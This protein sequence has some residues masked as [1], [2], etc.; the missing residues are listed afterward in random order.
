MFVWDGTADLDLFDQWTYEVDTWAELNELPDRVVIKLMI[1]FMKGEAGKFFMRHVSTRQS[2]WTVKKL[3]EALFDYCFPSDY[4]ARLRAHLER[5]YQGKN[6]VRDFVR[7]IQQLAVR[8]P[9]VTDFQLVQIFWKGLNTHLR[10][11]L[12]E[13]GLNPEKTKLDKLVKY[14]VRKEDAYTEAR[15]EERSFTGKVPGRKWGRFDSRV[16][17]PEAYQPDK[18]Q[19]EGAFAKNRPRTDRSGQSDTKRTHT[20]A[21]KRPRREGGHSNTLSRE[22]RDQ[23]RAEGRCFNCRETG[24]QSSNCPARKT[25]KAPSGVGLQAGAVNFESL[26]KL[27]ERARRTHGDT[28]FS[29]AVTF[30]TGPETL[31]GGQEGEWTRAH[32]LDCIEYIQSLFTSYYDPQTAIEAGLEPSEQFEVERHGG[33]DLFLI[34]DHLAFIGLPEEYV[35]SRSQ[36]EDPSWGVPDILQQEWNAW[37]EVT[38]PPEY[39][40]GFPRCDD[41]DRDH[42]PLYWLRAHVAA[43][44]RVDYPSLPNQDGLIQIETCPEG[45]VAT[46]VLHEDEHVFTYQELCDPSFDSTAVSRVLLD[47]YTAD[48]IWQWFRTQ[49]RRRR[50]CMRLMVG[51]VTMRKPRGRKSKTA[52]VPSNAVPAIERNTMRPKDSTR[53]A[54]MPIVVSVTVNG[55]RAR[56]LLDTGCMADFISTTL[57]DQ[58]KIPTVVLEKQ[59]PVQLAVQGSRSKINRVCSIDFTYQEI[60]CK[61][62]FDVA[63]LENYDLILRTPFIF[64]HKVAVGL[65]P[66]RVVVGSNEPTEMEGEDVAVIL[67]AA[68]ELL[69][70]E[71]DKLRDQ[72]K[73]EAADLC[74]DG[75]AAD[76]PPLRAINHSIPLIDES[77]V[78]SWRPSKCPDALK[79]MWQKKKA[80]YLASGRWQM[81]SGV[82]ASPMLMIPKPARDDGVLRLRTVVDKREQ[83]ANTHKLAAPLPDIDGILRNVVKHKYRSI[84]DGKD[85]YK[86]I[87]VIPEHVNRTLFTTPDGTMVSLVLQQGDVNGPT[88]YQMVMNHIFAP[89]IGVFMDVYLDDIV[90]YSDTIEDHMKHIHI[91]LDVLR[92]E[93]FYLGADK[94]NF[95]ATR[96]KILGHVI[97][98]HGIAMDPHKVDSV[99]NWKVPT[100]KSLLSSFLGAVGFL[101][102]DCEGIRIP[103]GVLAPLTS[104]TKIWKWHETHQ[105][106]FDEVKRKVHQ[107]RDNHRIALDYSAEAPTIDLV[108]DASLTG[109]SGYISQGDDLAMSRVVTFW[110]GKFN[111]A[112]QHYPVHEQELLAIVESLKQF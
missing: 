18:N 15:H 110:S 49:E 84:I 55:H 111:P 88:T 103:M 2:E 86:Q 12:I 90:I 66:S 8:F 56:A 99:A 102:P 93:R 10:V 70:N 40:T 92:R 1:Q 85:A 52:E 47:G 61:R 48:E 105:R 60:G 29:G 28:L 14:A 71:L 83:N 32:E 94:M 73:R 45:Y 58:L 98:E 77:K 82:N 20:N 37:I 42:C 13:K 24:H 72:L 108:T 46:T 43:T 44:L 4:K 34:T 51:A 17:G 101:A 59:L 26:E 33:E 81:S 67:S 7:D 19:R 36:L 6:R 97:D 11:Y 3:Y 107:W 80:A 76:L 65:N 21:P 50:R 53:K 35:V 64:Q 95:F 5:S 62:R 31:E 109:A 91:V 89:Y 74:Q 63:N 87:R 79:P 27:A 68:A 39:G 41:Q 112:Q 22:E 69:E 54:P 16:E 75:A 30:N 78:Y 100:N 25:A 38:A 106:A 57:V 96:L 9:H 23:L 104:S